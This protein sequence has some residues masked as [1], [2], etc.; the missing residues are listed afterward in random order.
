[1]IGALL[2]PSR[3][4]VDVLAADTDRDPGSGCAGWARS[5]AAARQLD[6]NGGWPPGASPDLLECALFTTTWQSSG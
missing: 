6:A 2:V 5:H 1:M 3:P 4:A